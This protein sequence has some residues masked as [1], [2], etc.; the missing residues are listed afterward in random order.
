VL[1]FF[2]VT[3]SFENYKTKHPVYEAEEEDDED[4]NDDDFPPPKTKWG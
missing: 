1:V 2:S 3:L 4:D